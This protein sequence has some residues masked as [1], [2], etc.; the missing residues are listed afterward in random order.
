M[1]KNIHERESDIKRDNQLVLISDKRSSQRQELIK[2]KS[3]VGMTKWYT[4]YSGITKW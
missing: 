3:N 2:A 1:K 4:S